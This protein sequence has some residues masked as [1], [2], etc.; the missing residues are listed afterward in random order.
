MIQRKYYEDYQIGDTFET[1]SLTIT[2]SH[3]VQWAGLTQDFYPLHMDAEYAATTVMK[4]RVAHGPFLF[5]LSVGQM[6]L[7]EWIN[8]DAII[9]WLG[10]DIKMLKPVRIGDT[11]HVLA[12]VT[13]MRE[14]SKPHQGIQMWLYKVINQRDEVVMENTMKFMMHRKPQK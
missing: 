9:A 4:E 3:L 11:V 14:T 1:A 6:C 13:E 7:K 8:Y 10:S 2:E 12:E 5:A